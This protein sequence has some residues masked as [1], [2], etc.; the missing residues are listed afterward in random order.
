MIEADQASPAGKLKRRWL[1]FRLRTLLIVVTL[2]ALWLGLW[3][4]RARRQRGAV[5]ALRDFS[6][7]LYRYSGRNEK[8]PGPVAL[9]NLAGIDFFDDVVCLWGTAELSDAQLEHLSGLPRLVRLEI[10]GKITGAGLRQLKPLGRLTSLRVQSAQITDDDLVHLQPLTNLTEL[11]LCCS[12]TEAGMQ[13]LK[14]LKRLERLVYLR[15]PFNPQKGNLA[16]AIESP[17][18]MEF[19]ECPL[20]DVLDY[21]CDYHDIKIELDQPGLKWAAVTAQAKNVPLGTALTSV[22]T[23]LQLDWTIGPHA[24]VVTSQE[25]LGKQRA[26][27]AALREAVPS[28]KTVCVEADVPAKTAR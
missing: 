19:I 26:A 5:E 9:H 11:E 25:A 7:I 8:P 23:P 22:L 15:F 24:L 4:D 16:T 6:Y 27:I 17:S 10:F 14:P 18:S 2:F 3:A 21:Y 20:T 28:L 13:H 12:I 1:Q